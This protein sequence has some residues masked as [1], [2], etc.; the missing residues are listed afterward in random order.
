MRKAIRQR[1]RALLL[2]IKA[3]LEAVAVGITTLEEEF[4]ANVVTPD[5]VTVGEWIRPQLKEAYETGAVLP[6]LPMPKR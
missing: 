2:T 1:W 4:L 3:K 5:N 6:M